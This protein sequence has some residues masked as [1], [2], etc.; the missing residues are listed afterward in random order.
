MIKCSASSA[1]QDTLLSV[2]Q[3][4][5]LHKSNTVLLCKLHRCSGLHALCSP[6]CTDSH[7][8]VSGLVPW[9]S[10]MSTL[11]CCSS[12]GPDRKFDAVLKRVRAQQEVQDKVNA[13]VQASKAATVSMVIPTAQVD[14]SKFK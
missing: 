9:Y 4:G 2:L 14:W 1:R 5:R 13:A 7:R 8:D 11:L 12:G 3:T 10:D 6:P